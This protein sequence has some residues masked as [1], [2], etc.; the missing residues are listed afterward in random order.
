MGLRHAV[1]VDD[2]ELD[3]EDTAALARLELHLFVP[4]QI[5]QESGRLPW[6]PTGLISVMPQA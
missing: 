6:V 5:V 2:L 4:R 3:A 1:F